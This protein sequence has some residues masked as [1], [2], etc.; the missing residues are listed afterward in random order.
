M[1]ILISSIITIFI[2]ISALIILD[3]ITKLAATIGKAGNN[4]LK[5]DWKKLL[6]FL[7]SEIVPAFLIWLAYSGINLLIAWIVGYFGLEVNLIAIIPMTSIMGLASMAIMA[8]LVKSII[9]NLKI[10]GIN[11]K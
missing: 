7:R 9:D 5:F 2:V 3:L 6:L 4:E 1:N 10:I 11:P 8:K